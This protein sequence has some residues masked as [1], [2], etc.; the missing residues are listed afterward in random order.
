[1]AYSFQPYINYLGV[2][3]VLTGFFSLFPS[4]LVPKILDTFLFPLDSLLRAIS[5]TGTI[6]LFDH[7]NLSPAFRSMNTPFGHLLLGA[8][9][10]ASGGISLATFSLFSPEW[11]FSTPPILNA[12][13]WSSADVWGGALAAL[14][15][16]ASTHSQIFTLPTLDPSELGRAYFPLN[17]VPGGL[18]KLFFRSSLSSSSKS[19]DFHLLASSPVSIQHGKALAAIALMTVFGSRVLYTHWLPRTPRLE[20]RKPKAKATNKQ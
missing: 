4:L 13:L 9:A 17:L 14:L 19:S 2:H 8:L 15:F 11:R 5:V 12:G 3:L 10:S 20:P 7:P 6:A 16:G 18:L 1:M